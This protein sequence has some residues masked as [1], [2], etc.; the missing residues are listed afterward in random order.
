[1]QLTITASLPKLP[2]LAV[3]I[4]DLSQ[5]GLLLETPVALTTGQK[6]QVF[7][8]PE[9]AVDTTVV[10]SSH[11]C[12]GCQFG[13]RVPQA[14]ISAALLQSSPKNGPP[15][16]GQS[17]QD[18]LSQLRDLNAGIER[19]VQDLDRAIGNFS[20]DRSPILSRDPDELVAAA[21]PQ[22]LSLDCL[23]EL[24]LELGDAAEPP[25]LTLIGSLQSDR[26]PILSRDPD[27]PLGAALPQSPILPPPGME[28]PLQQEPEHSVEQE[29]FEVREA[30]Q[31]VVIISLIMA[32]LAALILIIA[33][34]SSSSWN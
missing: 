29:S 1:L 19:V 5:T 26:S 11:Q 2:D 34:W 33:L 25:T 3:A 9:G 18:A 21:L 7:L 23:Y 22:S 30:S 8:P 20:S 16:A 27:E 24:L 32:G 31:I 13:K 28:I 17:V 4:H 6:F 14:A 12:Y 10:W 15:E